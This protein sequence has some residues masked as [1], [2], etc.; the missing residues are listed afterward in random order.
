MYM[1]KKEHNPPHIHAL[2]QKRKAIFNIRTGEKTEGSLPKDK[3]K[4]VAAWVVLHKEELLANWE[5]AQ[6]GELP[7]DIDP[8]K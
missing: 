3:E 8:L 5:L 7:R 6:N 2:Y 4:L 1:G